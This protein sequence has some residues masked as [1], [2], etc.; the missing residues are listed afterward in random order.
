MH[1][2]QFTLIN[3]PDPDIFRRGAAELAYHAASS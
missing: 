1:P 2:D 3:S